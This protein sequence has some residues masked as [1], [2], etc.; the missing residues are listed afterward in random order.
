MPEN[1]HLRFLL[2]AAYLGLGG[3]ALWLALRFLLP[4]VLPFLVALALA[5]LL[6]RPVGFL[7]ARL[8]LPRWV[9]AALCTL[10]LALAL[11]GALLLAGWRLWYETALLLKGLPTLLSSLPALGERAESW[12]YRFIIAAPPDM[13]DFLWETLE[14][15]LARGAALPAQLYDT[16]AA[17]AAAAFTALPDLG[18]FLFTTVLATYF[19]SAGR[20]ALLAFF[21]RQ[22]PA[23]WRPALRN[24]LRRM[25]LTLG[26][27]L[28]AQGTLM[29]VTF[30]ELSAGF[31]VLGVDLALLLA[32]LVSL[33]DALP[34][35]GTGTV[36]LP[37]AAVELLAGNGSLA[38][39]LLALYLLVSAVRSL[40][41][42]KL[43]GDRVGLPPL[44]ALLAMYV[45]FQSFG[46]AGMVL[47]PLAAIL[48]KEL[49]DCGVVRLW[50]D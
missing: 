6:E 18:L 30:M 29:L 45:G 12:A 1:K 22:V 34:V 8:G 35:F 47:S 38:L 37:W 21:R 44:A 43:V 13:Q 42:P 23:A 16:V 36:L 26:G 5:A 49:H 10:L 2:I 32:A 11:S 25:R 46:V 20:P 9:S 3:L 24:G 7:T 14:T 31:L 33:V 41:E 15:V 4:W 50:R 19:S 48:L 28:K 40:L 17:W 39:G 27:W